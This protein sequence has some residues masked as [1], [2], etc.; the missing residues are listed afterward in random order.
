MAD[1]EM[2]AEQLEQI[3]RKHEEDVRSR[4]ESEM[5]KQNSMLKCRRYVA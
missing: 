5:V 3:S 1:M 2:T 4:I